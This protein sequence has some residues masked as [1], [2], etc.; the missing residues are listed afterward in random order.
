MVP[1][2][3]LRWGFAAEVRSDGSLIA[4]SVCSPYGVASASI[5]EYRGGFY[6]AHR[7]EKRK[8]EV[9]DRFCF[10]KSQKTEKREID[11]GL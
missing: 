3:R 8:R 5:R 11:R 1:A 2:I 7:N 9:D 10:A 4:D 6:S